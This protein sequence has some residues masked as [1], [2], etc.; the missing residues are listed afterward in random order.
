MPS[1]ETVITTLPSVIVDFNRIPKY[2]GPY[3]KVL[4]SGLLVDTLVDI[5]SFGV[6]QDVFLDLRISTHLAEIDHWFKYEVTDHSRCII[7]HCVVD[8]MNKLCFAPRRRR[9][10]WG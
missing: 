3:S 7:S 8:Q 1:V 10:T 4:E 6:A 9:Q 5:I 2:I